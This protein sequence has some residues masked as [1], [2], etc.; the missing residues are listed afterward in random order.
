MAIR[1]FS[2]CVAS[3]LCLKSCSVVHIFF[4][5]FR[6]INLLEQTFYS[7]KT[8][9]TNSPTQCN[10]QFAFHQV[11]SISGAVLTQKNSSDRCLAMQALVGFPTCPLRILAIVYGDMLLQ[12]R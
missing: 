8:C 9:L 5:Q 11:L 7:L 10:E 3:K 4:F 6:N 12:Q 1:Y 2:L